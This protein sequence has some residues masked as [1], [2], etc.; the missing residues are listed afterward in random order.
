MNLG[1]NLPSEEKSGNTQKAFGALKKEKFPG[2]T[3]MRVC[4]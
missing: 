2:E 3:E 1:V 4:H